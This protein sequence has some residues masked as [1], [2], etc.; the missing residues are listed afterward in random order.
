MTTDSYDAVSVSEA[1]KRLGGISNAVF[2]RL[3]N[4]DQ[5]RTFKVGRRRLVSSD[6]I[7]DFIRDRESAAASD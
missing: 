3:I 6:A 5:L 7:R 1:R 2:Y 4:E